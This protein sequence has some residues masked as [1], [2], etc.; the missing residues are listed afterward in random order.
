M[1]TLEAMRAVLDELH[2]TLRKRE[3]SED[4]SQ[5]VASHEYQNLINGYARLAELEDARASVDRE[6]E[7]ELSRRTY[8][9]GTPCVLLK[10]MAGDQEYWTVHQAMDALLAQGWSSSSTRPSV[11][12]GNMLRHLAVRGD[13]QRGARGIYRISAQGRQRIASTVTESDET[14]GHGE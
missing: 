14:T 7:L 11:I 1:D 3:G 6:R 12:V 2:A 10:I 8:T 5:T 13:V 9:D 4:P